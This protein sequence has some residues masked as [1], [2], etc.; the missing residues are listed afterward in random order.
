MSGTIATSAGTADQQGDAPSQTGPAIAPEEAFVQHSIRGKNKPLP[1]QAAVRRVY[2]NQTC[3]W[4]VAF[5]IVGNFVVNI[6]EKEIDPD[7][8]NMLYTKVWDQLDVAFNVVFLVELLMN[9]YGYGGPVCEFWRSP[10]NCF[11]FFIV[12]VGCVLMSGIELNEGLSKLKLLRAFRIFR[13]FKRVK[14]LN[15]IIVALLRAIP[16]VFNAFVVMFIFFCIYAILAVE[17]FRDFGVDGY[18]NTTGSQ[19]DPTSVQVIGRDGDPSPNPR[20]PTNHHPTTHIPTTIYLTRS[21]S[22]RQRRRGAT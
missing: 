18:Y 8:N 3:V 10:W 12:T 14:S 4:A 13:L 15:Q 17:L 11:D 7:V 6:V 9:M 20:T 1:Y 2:T 22:S 19:D 5:F 21:R 16:G